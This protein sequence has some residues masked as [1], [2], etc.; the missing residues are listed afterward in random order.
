MGKFA[1]WA[2]MTG[3]MTREVMRSSESFT[4]K[5]IDHIDRSGVKFTVNMMG[6]L[7][8]RRLPLSSSAAGAGI[9][10]GFKFAYGS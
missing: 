7:H 4:Q 5:L 3:K 1:N 10:T 8:T 2:E 9:C 6:Q